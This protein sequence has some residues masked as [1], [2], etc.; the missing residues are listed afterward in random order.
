MR[1]KSSAP[2]LVCSMV[3]F[4]LPSWLIV[5]TLIVSLPPVFCLMMS[6]MYFTAITV[7]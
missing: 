6:L 1:T 5:K 4:S 2:I 3:S 7:G